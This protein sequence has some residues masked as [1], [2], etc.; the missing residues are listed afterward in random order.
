MTFVVF[1]GSLHG[2][3]VYPLLQLNAYIEHHGMFE[4]RNTVEIW[5]I[6]GT[7]SQSRFISRRSTYAMVMVVGLV[8]ALGP[9]QAE[10]NH[11]VL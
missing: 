6:C 8:T 3:I 5:N 9:T 11:S 2:L 4:G 1:V 10:W 7:S